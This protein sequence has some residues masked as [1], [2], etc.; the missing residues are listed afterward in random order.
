MER[1]V[2]LGVHAHGEEARAR[3]DVTGE[4]ASTGARDG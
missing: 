1:S 4:R 3:L 2:G